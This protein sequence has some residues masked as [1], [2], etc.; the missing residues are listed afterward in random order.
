MSDQN[1]TAVDPEK[2]EQEHEKE[3]DD[4]IIEP[5][6]I[7]QVVQGILA[8]PPEDRP[9]SSWRAVI[10]TNSRPKKV[11]AGHRTYPR[12]LDP[13]VKHM[14][15]E[16]SREDA[17]PAKLIQITSHE[18]YVKVDNDV[19][20]VVSMEI[21]SSDGTDDPILK[22]EWT[23]KHYIVSL[24]FRSHPVTNPEALQRVSQLI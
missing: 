23:D 16:L 17:I 4:G 3:Q 18:Q 22:R 9:H 14:K 13:H 15:E 1:T 20:D 5:Y 8:P 10:Y 6:A 21:N 19:Y 7:N 24:T 2:C 12:E 11:F